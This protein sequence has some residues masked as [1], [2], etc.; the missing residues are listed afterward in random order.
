LVEK[1]AAA[2]NTTK[3]V[4]KS[5]RIEL[6]KRLPELAAKTLNWPKYHQTR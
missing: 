4:V 6:A 1:Q 3:P 2:E 5:Q